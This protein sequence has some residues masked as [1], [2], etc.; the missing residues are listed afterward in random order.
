[1]FTFY[2]RVWRRIKGGGYDELLH[3]GEFSA[4]S[5]QGALSK[6]LQ[7]VQSFG[8]EFGEC[9]IEFST[10]REARSPYVVYFPPF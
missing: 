10:A 3:Q 1:M 9:S 2:Y 4:D 7:L 5:V 6:A 8:S